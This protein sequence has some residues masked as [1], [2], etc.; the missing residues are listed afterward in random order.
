MSTKEIANLFT[1]L[2]N[3]KIKKA[4]LVG[5]NWRYKEALLTL[6]PSSEN[7]LHKHMAQPPLLWLHVFLNPSVTFPKANINFGQ[8]SAIC[9]PLVPLA[10]LSFQSMKK[11]PCKVEANR[12]LTIEV[13]S[14]TENIVSALLFIPEAIVSDTRHRILPPAGL[15]GLGDGVLHRA[16]AEPASI[17]PVQPWPPGLV[18]LVEGGNDGV[19]V[20]AGLLSLVEV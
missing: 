17:A 19:L 11:A 8:P 2:T 3:I 18:E 20:Q 1:I 16:I 10:S 6:A 13:R 9:Y 7:N 15:P 4:C 14:K 5:W 12:V